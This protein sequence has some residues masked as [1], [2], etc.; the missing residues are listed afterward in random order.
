MSVPA[1]YLPGPKPAPVVVPGEFVFAAAHLDHGHIYNQ[2]QGLLEAGATLAW[3]AARPG[4]GYWGG[5]GVVAL[6]QP[7][8]GLAA[9]H[10]RCGSAAAPL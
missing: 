6:H 5:D 2:T 1:D 8:A 7:A 9:P 4:C 10:V 3:V